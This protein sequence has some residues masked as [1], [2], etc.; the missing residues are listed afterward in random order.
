[1]WHRQGT[2][3]NLLQDTVDRRPAAGIYFP[4]ECGMGVSVT[5]E[6]L[7]SASDLYRVDRPLACAMD[8]ILMVSFTRAGC[9]MCIPPSDRY[10]TVQITN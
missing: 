5:L 3:G 8:E 9:H 1:M 6:K 10:V 7:S 2:A 4:D